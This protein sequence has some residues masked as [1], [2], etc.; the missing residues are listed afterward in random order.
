[1]VV[2][3][4][5]GVG[6]DLAGASELVFVGGEG[7][8]GKGAAGVELLGRDADL[9]AQ[10]KLAAVGEARA[11]VGIHGRGIDRVQEALAGILVSATMASECMVP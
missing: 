8:G 1:M 9:G 4:C 6:A 3:V 7:L 2:F 5:A 10:A 11:G